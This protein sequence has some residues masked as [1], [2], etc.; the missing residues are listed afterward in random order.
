MN[1]EKYFDTLDGIDNN[2][3][4]NERIDEFLCCKEENNYIIHDGMT[5]CKIC[6]SIIS[7]KFS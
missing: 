3:R 2:E 7:N 4:I 5:T 6:N 1:F